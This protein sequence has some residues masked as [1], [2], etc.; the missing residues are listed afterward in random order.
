MTDDHQQDAP[1]S[2]RVREELFVQLARKPEGVTAQ[3]V[4][5]VAR[6][7][8]DCVTIEAYHN[9]GRRLTHRG[10]LSADKSDRQTR[11]NL[12]EHGE[13]QWLDEDQVAA[14]IHPDYPLV[15]LTVMQESARQLNSV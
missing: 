2:P 3:E 1:L 5:E 12:G 7:K 13:G 4:F 14:I 8:G 15:A 9:L 11:Y 10:V 6:K